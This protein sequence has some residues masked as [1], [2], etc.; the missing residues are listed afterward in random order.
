LIPAISDAELDAAVIRRLG[1]YEFVKRAWHVLEQRPFVPNWHIRVLCNHL[2]ACYRREIRKLVICVPPGFM[3]TLLTGPFF[4]A[5][6][7]TLDP[8]EKFI[9]TSYGEQL[10][11]TNARRAK[12]LIESGWY[13]TRWPHVRLPP[14][15]AKQVA[16]FENS[17]GGYRLS[18]SM[19]GGV[20]GRHGDFLIC[21]DPLLAADARG[22]TEKLKHAQDFFHDTFPSR[23]ANPDSTVMIMI[24][25]RLHT[26]DPQ[27]LALQDPNW[28]PIVIPMRFDPARTFVPVVGEGDP[29]TVKGELAWPERVSEEEV[30]AREREMGPLVAASQ[31]QQSPIVEGGTIFKEDCIQF[32]HPEGNLPR[33]IRTPQFNVKV[34]SVD[35]NFRETGDKFS[36]QV[37]SQVH[38]NFFLID[39]ET[40][41]GGFDDCKQAI[42]RMR[43][44]H[45]VNTI[46]IEG[47]ANGDAI[48]EQLKKQ[49][50][51]DVRRL[52]PKGGKVA[53]A[54]AVQPFFLG[55]NVFFPH[56]LIAP[57]IVGYVQEYV[58]FTGRAGEADDQVDAG[59]YAVDYLSKN[60]NPIIDAMKAVRA[61][62]SGELRDL[63]CG[64]GRRW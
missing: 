10:A 12:R 13:K 32:H 3:K 11:E 62:M 16:F 21:D 64:R 22:D 63:M 50:S 41:H 61:D 26:A 37:W 28:T 30:S 15:A 18:V 51:G 34:I 6:V 45:N 5:W 29:R 20:T 56:P 23:A 48:Y 14:D 27:G 1:F 59:V 31:F 57:W 24:G 2:E 53:R 7:W 47:R 39:A 46:L 25:Q 19:S 9:Y 4:N 60:R 8:G 58:G 36:V 33:T 49:I 55:G 54:M 43:A 44:T 38:P 40:R 42:L 52:E 17:K 35:A